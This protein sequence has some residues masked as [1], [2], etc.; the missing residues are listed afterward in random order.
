MTSI[1][2]NADKTPLALDKRIADF[3][4]PRN[5]FPV[6][7][8]TNLNFRYSDE[9]H[10]PLYD[11][12]LST[13]AAFISE[14]T[15]YLVWLYWARLVS[16]VEH[17]HTDLLRPSTIARLVDGPVN[18]ISYASSRINP[19]TK[20]MLAHLEK[21][22]GLTLRFVA[23]DGSGG[24]NGD[25]SGRILGVSSGVGFTWQEETFVHEQD[26]RDYGIIV[27][28]HPALHDPR[29]WWI[30]AGCSRPGSVAA[31]K[32]IF[33]RTWA[34]YLV[35]KIGKNNW[36][37]FAAVFSVDYDPQSSDNPRNPQ[38]IST[39]LFKQLKAAYLAHVPA[40]SKERRHPGFF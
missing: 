5:S 1:K 33:E 12:R 2:V 16:M 26:H 17:K 18:L 32:L 4:N 27:R 34:E 30:F 10:T 19:C 13:T 14:V 6:C 39:I 7:V 37:S 23:A 35:K 36:E 3:L 40:S 38:I 25:L 31:R 15:R 29:V 24:V 8:L 11:T 20:T 9:S 22:Y 21:E 28:A